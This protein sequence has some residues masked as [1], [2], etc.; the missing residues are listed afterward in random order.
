M[1]LQPRIDLGRLDLVGDAIPKVFEDDVHPN[2]EVLYVLAT[3]LDVPVE[4]MKADHLKLHTF[5]LHVRRHLRTPQRVRTPDPIQ[6]D[7]VAE[8]PY[9]FA[10]LYPLHLL[11]NPPDV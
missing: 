4:R 10:V 8:A 2:A 6:I 11:P 7:R 1:L 3:V 5:V 9:L